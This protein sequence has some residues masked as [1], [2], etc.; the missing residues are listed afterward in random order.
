MRSVI[1]SQWRESRMGVIRLDLEVLT[2]VRVKE[3]WICWRRDN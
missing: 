1:L 2:T 3:F